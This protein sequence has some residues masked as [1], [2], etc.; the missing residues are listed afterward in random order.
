MQTLAAK[1][2]A[3]ALT[4]TPPWRSP[5]TYDQYA[6]RLNTITSSIVTEVEEYPPRHWNATELSATLLVLT[7]R[8]SAWRLDVHSGTRLGDRGKAA[9][10]AQVHS[11]RILP[12]NEWVSTMGTSEVSTRNCMLAALSYLVPAQRRCAPAPMPFG[13]EA[14][15]RALQGYGTGGPC[16]PQAWA[17]AR[18][19]RVVRTRIMLTTCGAKCRERLTAIAGRRRDEWSGM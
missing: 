1:L 9:C 6:E 5:E 2:F 8:E 19:R 4:F 10:L 14:V 3:V 16:K 18:A 7:Y 11:S 13:V 12:T 15:A 17:Y